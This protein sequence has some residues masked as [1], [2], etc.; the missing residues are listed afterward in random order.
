M[1]VCWHESFIVI[2]IVAQTVETHLQKHAS[3]SS[4]FNETRITL[5][6]GIPLK[7]LLC[8]P[9]DLIAKMQMVMSTASSQ[10]FFEIE[11]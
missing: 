3:V 6:Y 11:F 2:V 9:K 1:T 8:I 5:T 10:I 4:R 7:Q